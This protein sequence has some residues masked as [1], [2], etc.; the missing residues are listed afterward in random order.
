MIESGCHPHLPSAPAFINTSIYD[1]S[2]P[3]FPQTHISF[4]GESLAETR[5]GL[6][7]LDPMPLSRNQQFYLAT[8]MQ[9]FLNSVR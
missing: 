9:P 1:L 3:R 4:A 6:F 8:R 5:R 2:L 7:S